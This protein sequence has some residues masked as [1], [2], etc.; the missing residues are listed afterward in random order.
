MWRGVGLV[1]LCL[2]TF[3]VGLGQSAIT[4]SDEAYYAEAGREMVTSGDWTTPHYN[5]EPR[6]QKPILFYWFIAGTYRLA[7][8]TEWAAR[9]WA[10]LAG[11][12]L[13][14]VAAIVARRWSGP[15][16]GW[17][18][19]AVVATSF[20]VVPIA[21]QSLPDVP[22]A[23]F[24]SITVWAAIE[25]FT[26]AVTSARSS[27][28]PHHWLFLSAA[29]AALGM[30]TKGPVAVALPVTVVAP[31]LWMAWRRGEHAALLSRVRLSHVFVAAVIFV[32]IAAPWYLAV[33]RAQGLDYARQFFI[34]ENVER[35]ATSTYNSWRGWTYVPVIIAGLLPWSTFAV[36]WW[37]PVGQWF[38]RRRSMTPVEA[39][40]VCWTAGPLAFFMISVGSQPRYILPC[41]VPLSVLLARTLWTVA[42]SAGD[43]RGRQFRVAAIG[44]GVMIVL[45]GGLL[46]RAASVLAM[47]GEAPAF[48]GPVLMLAVGSVATLSLIFVSRK[49][50]P[51]V[52]A[53]AA[54][55]SLT[56]FEWSLLSP[57]RPEPVETIAA[58]IQAAGPDL[59]VCAC[60]AIGRSLSFYT[61]HPVEIAN[62]TPDNVE[63]ARR[64]LSTDRRVLAVMDLRGLDVLERL[65]GRRFPRLA[66]IDYLNTFVWRRGDT[67]PDPDPALV[68]R[69]VLIANR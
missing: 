20:G 19:G 63:E 49:S 46:W 54:A 6:L 44:S 33:M 41:L 24:V 43:Q 65:L 22:L 45:I 31:L 64:F 53:A 4:D 30:L 1:L 51:L 52:I 40:L 2:V 66:E 38:S 21:R 29:A 56:V 69:V 10:A 5:F 50:V 36:L 16:E 39:R 14:L 68:Q 62:V 58:A 60:G 35:F 42:T 15:N 48:A 12:G 37:Q 67:L 57:G 13:A 32:L 18:A 17:L 8:V 34:G 59:P 7:G 11:V 3:T 28:R 26:P 23:F 9:I 27:W 47:P 55:I 25:A 61:H